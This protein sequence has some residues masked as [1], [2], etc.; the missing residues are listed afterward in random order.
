M[1]DQGLDHAIAYLT[2]KR[3]ARI[4]GGVRGSHAGAPAADAARRLSHVQLGLGLVPGDLDAVRLADPV[5]AAVQDCQ[6][7]SAEAVQRRTEP[8]ADLSQWMSDDIR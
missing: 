4:E 1:P 5:V 2:A 6:Q 3:S 7:R 8:V